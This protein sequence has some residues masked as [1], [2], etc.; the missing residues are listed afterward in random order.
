VKDVWF[1]VVEG[2]E[3]QQGDLLLAFP[4]TR[5]LF[6]F[7]RPADDEI[8]FDRV[9]YDAIV[10]SQSCDLVEGR[11]K[12]PDV[13]LCAAPTLAEAKATEGHALAK[14]EN[15]TNLVRFALAGFHPLKEHV[16]DQISR[17]MSAVQFSLIFTAPVAYAR[18]V[19]AAAGPR[20]RL[21]SPY[22][23]HVAQRFGYFFSR[24]ALPD[25]LKLPEFK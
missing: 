3:L 16:S 21:R 11:E 18:A 24:I 20:L 4:H 22:R 13:V 17:P 19:A 10:L 23:E 5:P 8:E 15:R 2:G 25:E 14:S 9:T 12:I 1:D 7:P 6:T